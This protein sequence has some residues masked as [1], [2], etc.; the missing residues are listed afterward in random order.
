VEI[1]RKFDAIVAF[2]EVERFLDTPIKHYSSGMYV[3]LAFA[4]AAHLEPEILMVDEV[5][6]VGDAAFQRRCLGQM[7]EVARG[8]R[9]I[10]FVSHNMAAVTRLCKMALWLNEGR[11]QAYGDT[12]GVVAQYLA[13]GESD[14]GEITFPD[15]TEEAPGTDHVRLR[16]VRTRSASGRLAT[17]L[18]ARHPFTIEVEYR[19]L[20]RI[21]NLRVG[22]R[23]MAH[24]GA[25]V[26][27]AT[28]VDESET[29][30]RLPGTYVSRCTIPGDFLNYGQY[31]VSV[32]SDVPFM[33]SHISHFFEDRVLGFR[34]EQ[35]TAIG[36]HFHD[37]R[38]GVVRTTLPWQVERIDHS[39]P[40]QERPARMVGWSPASEG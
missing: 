7:G 35:T 11:V 20:Q 8:G 26:L 22:V 21:S 33:R 28:D 5:L 37:R 15:G 18:D 23:L 1:D 4:V 38:P 30:E 10:L 13:A 25:V 40:G 36:N 19:V 24:D 6:A 12:E 3:R 14:I 16:A 27:S 29:M 9:T 34:I 17:S 39:G 31:F 32:G 2:S